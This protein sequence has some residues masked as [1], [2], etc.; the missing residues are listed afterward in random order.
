[1]DNNTVLLLHMRYG[2]SRGESINARLAESVGN[3]GRKWTVVWGDGVH[4]PKAN[5]G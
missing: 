4:E 3:E 1:M 2:T 5:D